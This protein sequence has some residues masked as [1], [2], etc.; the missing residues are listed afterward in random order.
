[1]AA[2]RVPPQSSPMQMFDRCPNQEAT[3]ECCSNKAEMQPG[4]EQ[5]YVVPNQTNSDGPT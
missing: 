2:S 1:M 4:G 3:Q 5:V